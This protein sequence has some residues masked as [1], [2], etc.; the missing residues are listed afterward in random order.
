MTADNQGGWSM[1]STW[2]MSG[3]PRLRGRLDLGS[4]AAH[5]PAAGCPMAKSRSE[6]AGMHQ[7][8]NRAA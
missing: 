6:G 8:I 5:D 2:E 7:T 3:L 4:P 1:F